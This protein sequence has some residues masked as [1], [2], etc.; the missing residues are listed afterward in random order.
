MN[1]I[2]ALQIERFQVNGHQYHAAMKLGRF[3][4]QPYGFLNGGA[5]LAFAEITAGHA[6]NLL[7]KGMYHAVG[8]S[9]TA[10]HVRSMKA[11][12]Y[13]SA[14]G[15]L[16]HDGHRNHVWSIKMRDEK[17]NL[18]SIVTVTNAILDEKGVKSTYKKMD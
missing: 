13:L 1:L 14:E 15:E 6:S 11:E 9:V 8:M 17:N 10:N 5:T 16:L 3:H 18:I 2:E 7:G 12:G 4:E